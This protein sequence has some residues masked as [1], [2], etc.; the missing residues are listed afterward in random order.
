[1][2]I[3]HQKYRKLKE[4]LRSC[5]TIAIAYSGGV[6]S[7]F[8]LKTAAEVL[9]GQVLAVTAAAPF[10]PERELQETKR[11]CGENGIR[12]TVIVS[13]VLDSETFRK[14]PPDRCYYCKR[15][16]FGR[17]LAE[18]D[19][20]GISVIAEGSN[21]DDTGDYRPGL[22]KFCNHS[23]MDPS[24][25]F[26]HLLTC[27]NMRLPCFHPTT[28]PPCF[29]CPKGPAAILS[30]GALHWDFHWVPC[31]VSFILPVR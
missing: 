25:S 20:N 10:V 11:F 28:L 24:S 12:Q 22:T 8:L 13:D 27:R 15:D 31:S 19:R 9:G 2:D 7:T 30:C 5:G 14:N 4:I 18:A 29:P 16:L 3:L 6:D 26:L 1:M 23:N 17:M 21:M